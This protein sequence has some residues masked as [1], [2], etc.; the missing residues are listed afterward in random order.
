M[1][2]HENVLGE[3]DHEAEAV[4]IARPM[5]SMLYDLSCGVQIRLRN[6]G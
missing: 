1:I 3:V 5:V 2:K 4:D 6:I